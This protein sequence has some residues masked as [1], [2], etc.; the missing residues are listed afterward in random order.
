MT[1]EPKKLYR[2]SKDRRV[3]GVCGGL[4]EYFKIDTTLVRLL[5]VVGTIL[6]GPGLVV[7]IICLIFMPLEPE[8]ALVASEPEN[9]DSA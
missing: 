1:T 3:A 5:F 6:G 8:Q 7:Y 4:A 9:P 2:S